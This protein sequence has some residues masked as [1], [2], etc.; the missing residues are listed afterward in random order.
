MR[1]MSGLETKL[2]NKENLF[3]SKTKNYIKFY[4]TQ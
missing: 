1:K 2:F 4:T 3:I